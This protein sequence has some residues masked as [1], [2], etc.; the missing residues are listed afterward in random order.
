MPMTCKSAE[1]WSPATLK[2]LLF[3]L[4][5]SLDNTPGV[6]DAIVVVVGQIALLCGAVKVEV[7]VLPLAQLW[8]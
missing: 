1:R 5:R 3:T 7:V 2:C 8:E 6:R 4:S